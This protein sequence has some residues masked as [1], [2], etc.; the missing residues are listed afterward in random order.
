MSKEEVGLKAIPEV[1]KLIQ[2]GQQNGEITY[3]EINE[4]LPDKILNSDKI[5]DIFILINQLGIDVVE[6]STKRGPAALTTITPNAPATP[7]KKATKKAT[8]SSSRKSS[9]SEDS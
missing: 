2:L 5:D 9:S 1:Q 4:I 3:D 7:T 6:E 8:K